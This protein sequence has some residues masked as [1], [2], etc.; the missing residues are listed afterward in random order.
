MLTPAAAARATT[1][2]VVSGPDCA[3]AVLE[4][5]FD[6][7]TARSRNRFANLFRTILTS[8]IVFQISRQLV[9]TCSLYHEHL[10]KFRPH[11]GVQS[12]MLYGNGLPHNLLS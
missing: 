7:N 3:E 1:S 9:T 8:L 6:S 12:R 11:F 2:G 10:Y 4:K 5:K